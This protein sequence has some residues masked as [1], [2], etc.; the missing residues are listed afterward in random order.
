MERFD[1]NTAFSI[2]KTLEI[3][4][5]VLIVCLSTLYGQNSVNV[6]A[7]GEFIDGTSGWTLSKLGSASATISI[8]DSSVLSGINSLKVTITK[9]GDS[10]AAV[11][12]RRS[13][14]MEVGRYYAVSFMAVA[15]RPCSVQPA[16][17]TSNSSV[18]TVWKGPETAVT[19]T[20]QRFGPFNFRN[21]LSDA[22]RAVSIMMGGQ[23]SLS[24]WIDSIVVMKTDDPEHTRD[25]EAFV[26]AFT[27]TLNQ[28]AQNTDNEFLKLHFQSIAKV[29]NDQYFLLAYTF[30]SL[31]GMYTAMTDTTT[32]WCPRNLSSY[33]ERKRPFVVSWTSPTDGGTSLAY[34]L[35]P[36]NWDPEQAYP[37][38]ISLHGLWSVADDPIT[39]MAYDLSRDSI[40]NEPYDDGYLVLPW[41][42]GN[43]WYEGISE[44]DI[45]ECISVVESLVKVNPA[46]KYLTGH[47]MGG[48]GAWAIGQKSAGTW[49][50]L[51]IHAGA[52]W[53]DNYEMLTPTAIENLKNTP[54][55][56]TCGDQDGLLSLNQA[57]YQALLDAGNSN[58]AFSIFSGG[59]VYLY[60]NVKN[61]YEWIRN[62]SL[63]GTHGIGQNDQGSPSIFEL[64]NSYPN[65]F[66]PSTTIGY[67]LPEK[68]HVKL[69]IY[70]LIGQKI[71]TLVDDVKSAGHYTITWNAQELSSG[72]YFCKMKATGKKAF[73]QT[74]KL[75]LMK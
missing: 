17:N 70:N 36:K 21:Q 5:I 38:Y 28:L 10:L 25:D 33:L 3:T 57:V 50:A 19:T 75:L 48:Y 29:I 64:H 59:H 2:S 61:I 54:V 62:Y 71:T 53:W 51:G 49:A 6:I 60:D 14:N 43:L 26:A 30:G 12:V 72:M 32:Q 4:L 73:E 31:Q 46:R 9:G 58:V 45:W 68:A 63:G 47:S 23:D 74:Q 1:T 44:T 34:I 39:Y 65:P 40:I 24:V 69:E 41:G 37:L 27:D 52:L 11:R 16:F 18:N 56:F 8:S 22:S 13:F 67:S 42:R 15:N 35:P 20:P 66:N 7:N 55:Y